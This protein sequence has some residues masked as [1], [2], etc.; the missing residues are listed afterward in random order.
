MKKPL[1]LALSLALLMALPPL[2]SN[3]SAAITVGGLISTDTVWREGNTYTL[4]SPVGIQK[5]VTLTI[6]PGT[7]INLASYYLQV[8]GTLNAQGTS[9]KKIVFTSS[10]YNYQSSSSYQN[11]IQFMETSSRWS[12]ETSSGCII[13]NAIFNNVGTT[14]TG[15]SPKFN[16]NNYNWSGTTI[17]SGS[18]TITNNEYSTSSISTYGSGS[19]SNNYFRKGGTAITASSTIRISGNII[20][21]HSTGVVFW[22]DVTFTQNTVTYCEVGIQC[23]AST[24]SLT[25]NYICNNGF[26]IKGGG[27]IESNTIMN[28]TV[29]IELAQSNYLASTALR[30]NNIYNN[31]HYNLLIDRSTDVDAT[32]NY[33]GTS[34]IDATIYDSAEDFSKGK[35]NYTPYLSLPSS[36]APT[37]PSAGLLA[38]WSLSFDSGLLQAFILEVA[39]IVATTLAISWISLLLVVI[40]RKRRKKR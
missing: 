34:N 27:K 10:G 8:N 4:V 6:E 19:I 32:N 22:G 7:T 40:V 24:V 29:G 36:S 16:Q 20:E 1:T 5:S 18:P 11:L 13:Q 15:A 23:D 9:N 39:E 12:D 30:N 2:F 35:V 17:Y 28:N 25:Q 21:H 14:V 37:T 33:W 38:G 3:T 31:T 26:G